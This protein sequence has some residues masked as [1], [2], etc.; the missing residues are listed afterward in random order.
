MEIANGFIHM[1]ATFFNLDIFTAD[2]VEFTEHIS[3]YNQ[4]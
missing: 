3:K 2:M 4:F 1:V